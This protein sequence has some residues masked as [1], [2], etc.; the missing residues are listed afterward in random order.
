MSQ[1]I[2]DFTVTKIEYYNHYFFDNSHV[3]EGHRHDSWEINVVIDGKIE[4]TYDDVIFTLNKGE[5]FLCEPNIFHRNRIIDNNTVELIVIHFITNDLPILSSFPAFSLNTSDLLLFNLA[6]ND[7]EQFRELNNISSSN[8][9]TVPS[10]FKKLLEVFISRVV[11]E[12]ANIPYTNKKETIIYNKAVTYMKNN[13]HK[14]C[15]IPEI[16]VEC[17]VCN[18]TLKNIFKKY[19]GQGVNTF[20]INM[21]LEQ[22]KSYMQQGYSIATISDMLGFTSQAYFSQIFKKTYGCSPLKYKN[23]L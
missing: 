7:Y 2:H 6:I 11:K 5:I 10:S 23:N 13:L 4:I 14:N 18:T 21:R 22:S 3:F 19:T 1:F 12:N 16:A 9:D 17:C 20:F 8:I 15:S